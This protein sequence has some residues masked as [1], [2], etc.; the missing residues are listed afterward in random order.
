MWLMPAIVDAIDGGAHTKRY[1]DLLARLAG[2][3]D[4]R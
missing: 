2:P 1:L 4:S 3:T